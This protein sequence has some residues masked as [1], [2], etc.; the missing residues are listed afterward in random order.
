MIEKLLER[1]ANLREEREGNHAEEERVQGREI[2][3]GNAVILV[4]YIICHVHEQFVTLASSGYIH[5]YGN[6]V[7]LVIHII[8]HVHEHGKY[9]IAYRRFTAAS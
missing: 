8:C 4:I 2:R 3:Y 1:L 5:N 9:F 6:A 7:I